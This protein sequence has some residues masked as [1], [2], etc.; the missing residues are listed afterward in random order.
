MK[1]RVHLQNG[2][3]IIGDIIGD[4]P[5]ALAHRALDWVLNDDRLFLPFKQPNGKEVQL[6]KNAIAYISTEE[7]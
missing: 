3:V 2:A 5:K 7:T 6:L 4:E 1:V